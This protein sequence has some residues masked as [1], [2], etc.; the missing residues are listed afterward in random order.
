MRISTVQMQQIALNSMLDQQTKLS[1]TQ[2][3]V[4][5][6]QRLLTPADDPIASTAALDLHQMVAVTEQ[7][8]RAAD[9][10]KARLGLEDATLSSVSD[11]L[12]RVRELAVQTGNTTLT[13]ED[14]RAVGAEVL[15]SIESLLGLANTS[16]N[17]GDYLFAGYQGATKPFASNSSG[18]FSYFGDDGQRRVQVG[19]AQ[20]VADSDAGSAVFRNIKNGNGTFQTAEAGNTGGGANR[21]GAV[22]N[23]GTVSGTFVPETYTLTFTGSPPASTYTVTNSAA[24]VIAGPAVYSSGADIDL[25]TVGI[26]TTITGSPANGDRFVISPSS[27]QDVFQTVKNFADALQQGFSNSASQAVYEKT[28]KQ[29]LTNLDQALS[30]VVN[31]RVQVGA[32]INTV[33]Q[34]VTSNESYLGQLH[35]TLASLEGLDYAEAISRLNLQTA[36]LQA[37][38]QSFVRIQGLSLFNYLR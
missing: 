4:A 38:Q 19:S 10:V 12:Q 20:S 15:Q 11:V 35:E 33:D 21:G 14:R 3:Q 32:R 22:I 26:K 16:D 27:N 30:N 13:N 25:S 23:S 1:K 31:T 24:T 29:T 17:N 8:Q 5:S 18:G 36:A 28:I 37:A 2:N 6:G 7:Q 9:A 34:Q